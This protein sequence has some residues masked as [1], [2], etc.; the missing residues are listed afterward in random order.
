[1]WVKLFIVVIAETLCLVCRR[2]LGS[3]SASDLAVSG[4]HHDSLAGLGC[5]DARRDERREVRGKAGEDAAGDAVA[6]ESADEGCVD[7]G[8][9]GGG[10]V[11]DSIDAGY[12]V[13][14]GAAVWVAGAGGPTRAPLVD[15][16]WTRNPSATYSMFP[17]HYLGLTN[18]EI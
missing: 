17:E 7:F 2:S 8:R 18:Q 15:T 10:G 9:G 3:K 11:E 12:T 6:G 14:L 5:C 4:N 16:I 13:G 1:M